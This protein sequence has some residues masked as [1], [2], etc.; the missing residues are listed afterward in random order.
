LD[1]PT[2]MLCEIT[3]AP[4]YLKVDVF[5]RNTAEETRAALEAITAAARSHGRSQILISVH[6]SRPIFRVEQSGLL[7]CFRELATGSRYRIALTGDSEGLR[8]SQQYVESLARRAGI[9][10]RS[11]PNHQ[12][13]LDWFRDRRWL[14]D[15]RLRQES[16]EVG[17]RR[18][19]AP[20]RK[21]LLGVSSGW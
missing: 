11:F 14:S 16:R 10:V 7:D 3:V 18:Q 1:Q 13:A 6:T 9:N 20:R 2:R 19:H 8:L 5:N 15:R 17:E 21:P 12:S 4:S